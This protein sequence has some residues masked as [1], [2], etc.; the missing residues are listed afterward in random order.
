VPEV[1][2]QVAADPII[3]VIELDIADEEEDN[4]EDSDFEE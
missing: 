1:L 2:A 4:T 3:D